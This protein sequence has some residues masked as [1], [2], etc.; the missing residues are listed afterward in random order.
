TSRSL[1]SPAGTSAVA[2]S[3]AAQHLVL[4]PCKLAE[5]DGDVLCGTYEVFENRSAKSGRTINLK[6]VVLKALNGT[7]APE[8]SFP[9]ARGPG[10]PATSMVDLAHGEILA[11]ARQDHDIVFVDQRGTGGSNP[12]LCD[13]GDDPRDLAAF[14]GNIL[15]IDKVRACRDKLQGI[16]D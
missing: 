7:P 2:T 1:T 4:K 3:P 10:A 15:S 8:A 14:F 12:L 13:V 6:I 9:L 16:A 5:L 11:P